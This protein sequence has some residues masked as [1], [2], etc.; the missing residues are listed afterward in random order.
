MAD[1]LKIRWLGQGGYILEDGETSICI[2]PYLSD[3]VNKVAGRA[4]TRA[5]PVAPDKLAVDAVICTHNHLDHVDTEAIPKM[6]KEIEFYAPKDCESTL[7]DLGVKKYHEFDEGMSYNIGK[8]KITAVFADHTVPA[9]GVAVEY[10]CEKLYFSG[11]TY[12]NAKLE[13]MRCDYMFVCI[14]GKLGNMNADEAVKLANIIE[15]K[16]AV[17]NHYDMFE[18][19]SENP[20][21]FTKRVKNGFI[22]EFNRE[23]EVNGGCLI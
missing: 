2:D 16:I 4:R 13:N 15:P 7:Y 17:P 5:V 14:N 10:A 11:D 20:E 22:M 1:V 21:K 19:N 8:F 6:R 23:Y 9:I 12:Y 3:I 18:S